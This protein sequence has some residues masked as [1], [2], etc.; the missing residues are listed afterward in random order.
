MLQKVVFLD[1]DGVVNRDSPNYIKTWREF[2][3]LP[4][5]LDAL[6]MLHQNGFTVVLVTNQSGIGRGL[7]TPGNLDDIHRKMTQAISAHDGHLAAIF[8]CPHHPDDHCACRKPKPGMI[9]QGRQR[10]DIDLSSAVMIG[11]SVKDI[12]CARNAGCAAAVLVKTGNGIQ[13]EKVLQAQSLRPDHVARDLFAAVQWILSVARS[14]TPK[15][16][17][18]HVR[19]NIC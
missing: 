3:F 2:H 14:V 9:L 1:R 13:A 19:D 17:R 15:D 16:C 4:R 7:I 8:H 18:N 5:S 11:D 6:R 10:F 12:E